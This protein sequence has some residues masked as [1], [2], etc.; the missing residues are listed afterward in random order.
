MSAGMRPLALVGNLNVDLWVRPVERF[1]AR[2]EEVVIDSARLELAGTAGYAL[3]AC[4]G[5]GI[6]VVV[7]STVGDDALGEYLLGAIERLDIPKFGVEILPGEETSLGMVFIAPDGSRSIL[8]TVGAHQHM[9][10]EVVHR[11]DAEVAKCG[12][13]FLCGNYLLP[14]FA[15]SQVVE[16]ASEA[17]RRGQIVVFDPSWDPSGWGEDTRR[18]TR[19]L[20]RMVDIYMPNVEEL[21]H[22]TG[23]ADWREA[24]VAVADL[25]REM[26]VKRGPEGATYVR[27]G[28][29]VDVPAFAVNAINTI[30]AGDVFDVGYLYGR[31]MGWSSRRRLEFAA[32]LAAMVVAQPG[33]RRYPSVGA[34][35]SFLR[36]RTGDSGW[37]DRL[38]SNWPDTG[39]SGVG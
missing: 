10:L 16:Y 36:E 3:L 18:G 9:S 22:L 27:A 39:A 4:R 21:K 7:V 31:R 20:L 19:E 25:P 30:G 38:F 34:V 35:F 32:A 17:R 28:E 33:A 24:V 5:L 23:R 11:H 13:V 6:D 14:Q 1:P 2:D 8:S 12:E 15:P 26:V 29:W 37:D